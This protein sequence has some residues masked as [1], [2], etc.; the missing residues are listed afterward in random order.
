[1]IIASPGLFSNLFLFVPY[2]RNPTRQKKRARPVMIKKK[3]VLSSSAS[4]NIIPII[5]KIPP[6]NN[7][8]ILRPE[9]MTYSLSYA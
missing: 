7:P 9:E 5:A 1:V 4:R 6:M 8:M 2:E 3:R